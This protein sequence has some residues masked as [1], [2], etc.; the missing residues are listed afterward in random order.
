MNVTRGGYTIST[1]P[2]RLDRKVIHEFLVSSYWA[3]G[4]P[5][6]VVDRSID[7]SLTFGVYEGTALVG[8]ARAITDRATFAYLS[9][10]FILDA[11]R[12]RGLGK[13]L[14]EVIRSHPD[15][16]DLRRWTLATRDAHGLYLQFGFTA[17]AHPDRFMEALDP[18]VYERASR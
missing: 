14:M 6:A 16:Q 17:L 1:D 5:R 10:V 13:W 9:D 12:G 11:H 3:R 4:I 18:D 2:E 8:F 15:L 7:N